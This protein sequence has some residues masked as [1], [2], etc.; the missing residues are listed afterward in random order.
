MGV[1]IALS[2]ITLG[3]VGLQGKFMY[4]F[5][6]AAWMFLFVFLAAL[7]N[8][9][10]KSGY[11]FCVFLLLNAI[12]G[13]Y[14][15]GVGSNLLFYISLVTLGSVVFLFRWRL[16]NDKTVSRIIARIKK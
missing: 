12:L 5:A 7:R 16:S 3:Y 6:F 2:V 10:I 13:A 14:F 11:G 9:K 15:F 1:S 4:L 8:V